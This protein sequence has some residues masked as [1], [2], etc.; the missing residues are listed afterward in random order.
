MKYKVYKMDDGLLNLY[1]DARQRLQ[2]AAIELVEVPCFSA[3]DIIEK[4][5][6]ADG[7]LVYLEPINRDVLQSL[8]N[9]KAIA[10]CGVGVDTV[11][12]VEATSRGIQVTN[13]PD[14][15]LFEVATHTMAMAL[16]FAR[17]L[18][19]FDS[20]IKSGVWEGSS[21]GSGMRRPSTQ[22]FGILGFGRI[23]QQVARMAAAIGYQ[24]VVTTPFENEQSRALEL[25]VKPVDFDTLVTTSDILT[26][27]VPLLDSTRGIIS[28]D[29][30]ARM[31]KTAILINV[32]RGGLVDEDA[33]AEQLIAGHL[34]G[35][36]LDV[37]GQEPLGANASIRSAPNVLLTPHVAYL[38]DDSLKEVSLKATDQIIKML[39]GCAPDYPVNTISA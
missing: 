18:P 31:K 15:N 5:Q 12:L 1:P 9:L 38:S 14:A 21:T 13:V 16:S 34:S 27:H 11:D 26:V 29:V 25:G 30:L 32:S 33:L 17:R 36:A 2:E 10:R 22:T 6:D 37:F 4:C 23:G 35:A 24:V 19:L 8:P 7:L 3:E 28:A 39:Q 20:Q